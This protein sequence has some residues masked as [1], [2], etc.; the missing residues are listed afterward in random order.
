MARAAL[1]PEPLGESCRHPMSDSSAQDA[2]SPGLSRENLRTTPEVEA[3]GLPSVRCSLQELEFSFRVTRLIMASWRSGTQR[4]YRVYIGKWKK[5]CSERKVDYLR[6]SVSVGLDFLTDLFEKGHSY[7]TINTARSALSTLILCDNCMTFGSHP[8][9][10][11]LM[12]GVYNKRPSGSRYTS[13]WD[14]N[15]VLRYLRT[16]SPV[17]DL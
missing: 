7:S 15:I 3:L 8:H 6:A 4:Q 10:I 2:S 13:T 9:V 5:F 17:K 11:K 12:K 14:V 1:V 16:L